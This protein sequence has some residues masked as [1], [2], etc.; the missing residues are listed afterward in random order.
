[1]LPQY[2]DTIEII[3]IC[4]ARGKPVVV[5]GPGVTSIPYGYSKANFQVLGEAE[6]I[7]DEFIAA[8]DSGAREA[9]SRRKNSRS[10]SLRVPSRGSTS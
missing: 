7:I 1:M 2:F 9:S 3:E 4:R 5:G 6:G 8:W 10:T